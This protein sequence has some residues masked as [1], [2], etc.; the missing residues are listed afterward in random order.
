MTSPVAFCHIRLASPQATA[1]LAAHLGRILRAGDTVLVEGPVGAGKTT[2]A[3]ALIQSLLRAP[4]DIPSP[5]YTLVQTYDTRAGPLWHADLYRIGDPGEIEELGLT[6][7]FETAI[8]LVEWPDRL[9]A[10]APDAALT[11]T[12]GQ[13]G[14][15]DEGRIIAISGAEHTW[16][17]RIDGVVRAFERADAARRFIENAGWGDADQTVLAGDASNRRYDRLERTAPPG[18]AVLMDAPPDR[19]EDVSP[20]VAIAR[21]LSGLG[22]SAPQ[23]LAADEE[24]GFLLIEDLGDDLFARVLQAGQ[25][26]EATLYTAAADVLTALHAAPPARVAAYDAPLM[27]ELAALAYDKYRAALVSQHDP[28]R[29]Q[30]FTAAFA[31]VLK[32]H[33]ASRAVLVLRDYHAEN[34]VWLP[35]RDGAARVGLLDFQD[36]MLGHPAYDL[37]SLL[38][39]ARRDV[40]E[41]IEADVMAHYAAQTGVDPEAFATAYAVLGA[42]RNLRILGVFARLSTDYGKPHYVDFIPRVWDL[43]MRDLAHPALAPVADMLRRDLPAPDAAV[44]QRLKDQCPAP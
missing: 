37:V 1:S 28:S 18:R 33:A 23:I 30:R 27:T 13:D 8:S 34:L 15:A 26:D 25:A 40:P 2:L 19:G 29:R 17:A 22:L 3:R 41:W 5:T 9:G 31:Q 7:A 32:T 20:F 11:I 6:E 12:M 16:R 43:L 24:A 35:D 10:L 42:Q 4:E 39:D 44:L 38:Q 21:H 36:A 14:G